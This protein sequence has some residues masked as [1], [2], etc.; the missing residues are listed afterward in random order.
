MGDAVAREE[1]IVDMM[2]Y[3]R[4]TIAK[5]DNAIAEMQANRT[6]LAS[7]LAAIEAATDS[8]LQAAAADYS[9]RVVAKRPYE[10]A[11][12]AESLIREAHGRVIP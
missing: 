7:R 1:Q 6:E 4:E 3:L 5:F 8:D 2:T 10:D 11:Q 9:D 12:S